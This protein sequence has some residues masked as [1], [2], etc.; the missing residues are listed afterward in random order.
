LCDIGFVYD[1]GFMYEPQAYGAHA[2]ALRKQTDRLAARAH[3]IMTI[4]R[5]TRTDILSAYALPEEQI[6]VAYPGVDRSFS[7]FGERYRWGRPYFLFVGSLNK[8]KDIPL[9]LS[10]FAGFC[11]QNRTTD[12]LLVGGDFWP[13]PVIDDTIKRLGLGDRVKKAG[14]VPDSDLP[15]YYRGAVAFVST[16]LREGF[17]LPAAE[18][19]ACG[20]P[21]IAYNRGALGE[22]VGEGGVIVTNPRTFRDALVGMGDLK[23]RASLSKKAVVQAKQYQWGTFA[24]HILTCIDSVFRYPGLDPGSSLKIRTGSPPSR[25]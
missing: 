1:L 5:S 22:V 6:T 8:A 2:D 11:R 12:L 24:K 18:A 4:S 13:D 17:C 3:H 20:T 14:V 16:A 10:L 25:G 7:P 15:A 19:M 21:V 9:L 23:K